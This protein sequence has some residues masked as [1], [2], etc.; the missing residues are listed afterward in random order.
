MR[1][2]KLSPLNDAVVVIF[3]ADVVDGKDHRHRFNFDV[4][5]NDVRTKNMFFVDIYLFPNCIPT[6]NIAD[7]HCDAE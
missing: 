4:F 7:G 3:A 1:Y 5:E 2:A 6:E